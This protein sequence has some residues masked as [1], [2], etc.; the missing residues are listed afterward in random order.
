MRRSFDKVM[1]RCKNKNRSSKYRRQQPIHIPSWNG[2]VSRSCWWNWAPAPTSYTGSPAPP[3]PHPVLCRRSLVVTARRPQAGTPQATRCTT[4]GTC[5]PHTQEQRK[6]NAHEREPVYPKG[7]SYRSRWS[8]GTAGPSPPPS[9]LAEVVGKPKALAT[10]AGLRVHRALPHM[11]GWT[12]MRSQAPRRWLVLA[13]NGGDGDLVGG[14]V[15]R[16]IRA[17]FPIRVRE[18]TFII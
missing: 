2:R 9:A 7:M 6:L 18:K 12:G 8:A 11:E 14:V 10:W 3:H 13:V 1:L 4:A 17:S 5:A 15:R 16:V